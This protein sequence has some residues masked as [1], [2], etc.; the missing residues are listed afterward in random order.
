[1]SSVEACADIRAFFREQVVEATRS[2]EVTMEQST[3][4]YLVELLAGFA[5]SDKVQDLSEPFVE[6]LQRALA[7]TE[8]ERTYRFRNLG[9]SALYVSGFLPDSHEGRGVT[10]PYVVSIGARAYGEVS[11]ATRRHG[12][13]HRFLFEELAD[14]FESFARV[15]DEVREQTA[16]CT[17]GALLRLYERWCASRSPRL[18]KRL[19]R[20]GVAPAARKPGDPVIH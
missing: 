2:L 11:R 6:L 8:P 20:R 9:D 1:M 4:R 17:D 13:T 15:L 16:L 10:Q 14:L 7:A 12:S 19:S 5:V 18:L 3:E